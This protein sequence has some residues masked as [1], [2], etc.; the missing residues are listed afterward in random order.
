M[1]KPAIRE[2]ILARRRS[3]SAID[4][5][6]WGCL[7]QDAFMALTEYASA[8][9]IALYCAVRGEVP[10]DRVMAH[11][12]A[13][14]KKVCFPAVEKEGLVFRQI[15]GH[16]DLIP[17]GFGIPEPHSGCIPVNPADIDLFVVPGVGFDLAGQRIGYGRGY[18]DRAL[19]RLESSGRLIAFCFEFQLLDAIKADHHDV[20]MD[21]IITERRVVTPV[22]P[23]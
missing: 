7:V 18:Y 6:E 22:L 11:A 14:G 15:Q 16:Q 12:F 13:S 19:H 5:A 21:R 1:P 17:G 9:V 10:T 3:I 8:D 4:H 20:I 23:K 2:I